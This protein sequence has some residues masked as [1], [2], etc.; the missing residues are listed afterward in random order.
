M[1]FH[2]TTFKKTTI[3]AIT[4]RSIPLHLCAQLLLLQ[5]M[6]VHSFLPSAAPG[7]GP[8]QHHA[9]A[10]CAA[11]AQHRQASALG[12]A[13][14]GSA[15]G[16]EGEEDWR[17]FRARLVQ[18]GIR[19]PDQM[20]TSED[21]S[22]VISN[23]VQDSSSNG[24]GKI[25]ADRWVFSTDKNVERGTILLSIPTLDLC[26]GIA[27]N[28]FHRCVVLVT[29]TDVQWAAAEDEEDDDGEETLAREE[30]GNS[31]NEIVQS[32]LGGIRGILLNRPT[33]LIVEEESA[34]DTSVGDDDDEELTGWNIWYGG[35]ISGLHHLQ[36]DGQTEFVCLHTLK[37]KASREVSL[38]VIPGLFYTT[39]DGARKLV[40][41]GDACIS[42]FYSFGG[43]CAWRPGQLQLLEM[44][45]DRDEWI[46]V[47]M[48][49]LSILDELD[50]LKE[51]Q[52]DSGGKL[53]TGVGMWDR[54]IG[55]V[56]RTETATNRLSEKRLKFYDGML[57]AWAEE[58]LSYGS[59]EDLGGD[60]IATLLRLTT[61]E[62]PTEIM[63]GMLVRSTLCNAVAEADKENTPPFMLQDQEL[64]RGTV[65]ILEESE[66][67]T[68]GVILG[69]PLGG[70]VEIMDGVTLP[71]RY[72]GPIGTEDT[73]DSYDEDEK[74]VDEGDPF[75]WIHWRDPS[76]P[77][78]GVGTQLGKSG[79][80]SLTDEEVI[81][82]LQSGKISGEEIVVLA[83][84]C[85]WEKDE[86]LGLQGGGMLEQ[87][88]SLGAFE[89]VCNSD[90]SKAN[91]DKQNRLWQILQKQQV[92]TT[93]T[94][95]SNM[96]LTLEAWDA[97]GASGQNTKQTN[98][99]A[100]ADAA[101]QAWVSINLLGEPT[102]MDIEEIWPLTE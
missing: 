27:Q 48:D 8:P 58:N 61:E 80:C 60:A 65:L 85:V 6:L 88:R 21:S 9:L 76:L 102:N 2:V 98:K 14:D 64:H 30:E 40:A 67:S 73:L 92:L 22:G 37:S 3:I 89:V 99:E 62:Q 69:L 1:T 71:L 68:I 94:M 75:T 96:S 54:L 5:L 39:L 11:A 95:G 13:A 26:Q 20:S 74:D 82:S 70:E 23:E 43:Y 55:A 7:A 41:D 45:D 19:T 25:S 66:T 91:S 51:G 32:E 56:G 15:E 24:K 84:L 17:A 35:D 86:S 34:S 78:A 49:K 47:S 50:R 97:L 10:P 33:N 83:G 12:G 53:S 59:V 44:G 42:D 79:I 28:Y 90:G 101:L 93:E 16:G 31:R 87:I 77:P 29:D 38:E 100:L 18:T 36:T 63:P 52:K 57:N 72:G 4:M 81:S 46:S